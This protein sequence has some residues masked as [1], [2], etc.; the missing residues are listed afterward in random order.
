MVFL[1]G[2]GI[3]H[4]LAVHYDHAPGEAELQERYDRGYADG[5]NR[6]EERAEDLVLEAWHWSSVARVALPTAGV[7]AIGLLAGGFFLGRR[8]R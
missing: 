4:A 8:V 2:V 6:T 3:G 7:L 1:A 5:L